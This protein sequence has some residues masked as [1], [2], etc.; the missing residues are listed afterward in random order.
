MSKKKSVLYCHKCTKNGHLQKDCTAPPT[1]Y[2]CKQEGHVASQCVEKKKKPE[3]K[4]CGGGAGD[5]MFYSLRVDVPDDVSSPSTV[6]GILTV[7]FGK[8]DGELVVRE[9][10]LLFEMDWIW[11]LKP[12]GP[13][14]FLVEFPDAASRRYVTR[15]VNGFTFI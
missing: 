5:K 7:Q 13:N 8:C 9:L 6:T 4:I 1:Y 3:L 12:L 2:T 15:F 11:R 10:D 14:E